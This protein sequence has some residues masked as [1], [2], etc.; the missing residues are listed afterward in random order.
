MKKIYILAVLTFLA[1]KAFSAD[2]SISLFPTTTFCSAYPS[3]YVTGSFSLNELIFTGNR[4]FTKGQ[5]SK[6]LI[7]N[8]NNGNYQFNPGLGTVTVLGAGVTINSYVITATTITVTITT[9]ATNTN[10]NVINFNNIQKRYFPRIG[11]PMCYF[12]VHKNVENKETTIVSHSQTF[13]VQLQNRAINPVREWTLET[14]KLIQKYVSE[15][16]NN[17]VYNRGTKEEDYTG[18]KYKVIYTPDKI[19]RT[20]DKNI[21]QGVDIK[22]IVLFE[23]KPY[24]SGMLDM[25]GE[26]G[27]GP[28]TFYVPFTTMRDGKILANFFKSP[29]YNKLVF[30]TL[31]SQ[32]LKTSLISHLNINNIL[33]Q[34]IITLQ[35]FIRKKQSMKKSKRGGDRCTRKQR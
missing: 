23:S 14:E 21:A 32:F 29:E 11:Q 15:T 12:L 3:S 20:D 8:F 31:T 34:P 33:Q 16:R 2:Y 22:K 18:G 24:S 1:A 19:I 7:L 35:K 17:A 27:V 9:A 25:E 13:R 28:H 6:T 5:T 10:T 4:G 30:V 26:Y